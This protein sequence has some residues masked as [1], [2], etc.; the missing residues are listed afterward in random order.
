MT[1]KGTVDAIRDAMV[2]PTVIS[3]THRTDRRTE[4][5]ALWTLLDPPV[6][7]RF[8]DAIDGRTLPDADVLA[9]R[10]ASLAAGHPDRNPRHFA[11]TLG[12]LRSHRTVYE[13]WLATGPSPTDVL[14]VFEDDANPSRRFWRRLD[15]AADELPPDW[16]FLT[17]GALHQAPPWQIKGCRHIVRVADANACHALLLRRAAAHFLVDVLADEAAPLDYAWKALFDRGRSYATRTWL[18]IQRESHSDVVGRRRNPFPPD[19]QP[20]EP[21]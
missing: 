3:L 10:E 4:F 17:L 12:V 5:D 13:N 1:I 9:H 2:T 6:H 14:A 8:F 16:Q 21:R 11:A 15:A 18:S 19:R 20:V 7:A